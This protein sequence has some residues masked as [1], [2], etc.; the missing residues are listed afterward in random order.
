MSA[1]EQNVDFL[2]ELNRFGGD[3]P[4]YELGK[5]IWYD[6][7]IRNMSDNHGWTMTW[8]SSN[9]S[10]WNIANFLT[11]ALAIDGNV[12]V[13]QSD[14]TQ[15]EIPFIGVRFHRRVVLCE[16]TFDIELSDGFNNEAIPAFSIFNGW[17][18]N[19]A[20]FRSANVISSHYG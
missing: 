9:E 3:F 12:S 6:S 10:E 19:E 13:A 17:K 4:S 15:G 2:N 16:V 1:F 11:Q 7:D 14:M 20:V 5:N 18:V 8:R